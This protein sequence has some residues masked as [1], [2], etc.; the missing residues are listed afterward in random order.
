MT[1]CEICKKKNYMNMKCKCGKIL[2]QKHMHDHNCSYDYKEEF[3]KKFKNENVKIDFEK[4]E[5]IK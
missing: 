4:F 3:R 1:R 5:K 2:C